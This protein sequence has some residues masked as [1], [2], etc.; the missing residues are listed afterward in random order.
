MNQTDVIEFAKI[1]KIKGG[2][3]ESPVIYGVTLAGKE[4]VMKYNT[5]Q[6]FI[7]I[8]DNN[9]G[10]LINVRIPYIK[11]GALPE[12]AYAVYW[13]KSGREDGKQ[14]ISKETPIMSGLNFGNSN[15]T[16]AF[17]QAILDA[18]SAYNLKLRKGG[19]ISKDALRD[20][21]EAHSIEDLF[22]DTNR[23]ATP[24]RV[25]PMALQDVSDTTPS[26]ASNWRHITYPGYI[27]PKYDGTRFIIVGHPNI[28]PDAPEG[29][30]G[31]DGFSRGLESYEGHDHILQAMLP[32]VRKYPGLYF[33]G[34]LWKI[35]YGLQHIS[36]SSRRLA[37]SKRPEAL[38][39]NYYIFDC[40]QLDEPKKPWSERMTMLEE[41]RKEF[42]PIDSSVQKEEMIIFAPCVMYN[43]QNEAEAL[44]KKYLADG[45]EGGVL[46]N[47]D[48]PYE[49]GI[50]K[51]VRS[52]KTMKIKPAPDDEWPVVGFAQGNR[53]KDVGAIK[54]ILETN[55]TVLAGHNA[56]YGM[57]AK[58]KPLLDDNKFDVVPKGMTY[59]E[60]YA[61]YQYLMQNP[62]YFDKYLKGQLMR[63]Q[64]SIISD[65][66]KPQQPK[67]LGFRDL[68]LNKKFIDDISTLLDE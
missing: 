59:K 6:I 40:F 19:A 63:V 18:R 15:E 48:S 13:T 3:M 22:D 44:Y 58:L 7:G 49:Y 8:R 46:R 12:E 24:W 2:V 38:K 43:D 10:E 11:R 67:A 20:P 64:Y 51:E 45:Y 37:D 50:V 56:K 35:G 16:T 39:L 66:G 52:Y 23:G 65:F 41:I 30:K 32:V 5:W 9:T 68:D 33:D 34:E 54:W 1:C 31:I 26:G 28:F 61:A 4:K 29:K 53:G 17:T 47:A 36:G 25:H 21:R 62:E 55:D 57:K 27:Q 14:T 42:F 60:R